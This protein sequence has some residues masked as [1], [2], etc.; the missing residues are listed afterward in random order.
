MNKTQITILLFLI[1]SITVFSQFN[2][3]RSWGTYFGD[4]RF[5]LAD[6]KADSN[7]NLYIV[8]SVYGTDI[9]N[10]ATFTN[11]TSYHQNYGGGDYDG[12]LIKFNNL[13][14]IVWG[15]FFGGLSEDRIYAID[16]D[17][18]NNLYI[19]GSTQSNTDI[20]TVGAFQENLAGTVNMFIS[21]FTSTG[22]LVWSTYYGGNGYDIG[23]KIAFDGVNNLYISG[24]ISSLNFATTGVFQEIKGNA[25][26]II[27]KFDL[28][29][30]RIW[31]TYYGFNRIIGDLKANLYGAIV[32]GITIDCPPTGSYNT[33]YGT[34][35]GYKP[36]PSN[37]REI[38]LSK[39]DASG[40]REWSTYYGGHLSEGTNKNSIGL[41]DDKIYMAGTSPNY[42]DQEVATNDT[43][44][45]NAIGSGGIIT[46]NFIAQ[47]NQN[48]TRNWGTYNGVYNSST[49]VNI[50]PTSQIEIDR[51]SNTFYNYGSTGMDNNVS[52]PDGYLTTINSPYSGDAYVCKFTDQN[53][54]SWGTYYGGEL[55]EKDIGFHFYNGGNNFYIVGSTQSFNQI[56]TTGVLQQTKQLFNTVDILPASAY[57]IF[58]AHFEPLPLSYST[59]N[60]NS[61]SI[62]PNPNN[63]N[64][65]VLLKNNE[66]Y[67]IELF[68]L[69]GKK[70]VTQELNTSETNIQTNNLSK[71]V[72]IAKITNSENV[73]YNTKI[74]IK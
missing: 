38:Y 52:T 24:G 70:I 7:G 54:K 16:I 4:E 39:L 35:N 3:Q 47:F 13:G 41:K 26:A 40:Q 15:T 22:S 72:Y 28:S 60:E 55:D 62:Y 64:F 49:T 57:N 45:P 66:N 56:A 68:D 37:C 12:F 8:G 6:S 31:A 36:L 74:V 58:I 46:S 19:T 27:A 2:F 18:N 42:Y 48:S 17:N 14:Q 30:N 1:N 53:T 11:S 34:S 71:G 67:T 9:T 73:S 29:G 61:F 50:I 65:T 20:A 5:I 44:Q 43:Y 32:T 63:G 10:L 25:V 59:F 21:K 33:Y 51:N 23:N 69:L